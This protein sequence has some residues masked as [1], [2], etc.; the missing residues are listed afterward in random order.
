MFIFE[1]LIF[2]LTKFIEERFKKHLG[3]R[4]CN[5]PEEIEKSKRAIKH[6][7]FQE[8]THRCTSVNANI[9]LR[10]QSLVS[11]FFLYFYKQIFEKN[12]TK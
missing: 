7:T 3:P 9:Y 2:F 12:N 11:R 8:I 5:A 1:C 4:S 10:Y 6:A